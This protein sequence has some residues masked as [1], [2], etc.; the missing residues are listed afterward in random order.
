MKKIFLFVFTCFVFLY[1]NAQED[2]TNR[3]SF[4]VKPEDPEW[5]QMDSPI[6]R[7]LSLQIPNNVI[8]EI[9]TD[10]LLGLCLDYPYIIDVLF[11]DNFQKG[12]EICISEFNGFQEL[13]SREDV[14]T[15]LEKELDNIPQII[16]KLKNETDVDKGKYSFRCFFLELL[17]AQNTIL[18]K[19]SKEEIKS[20]CLSL[21]RNVEAKKT[22][23]D[24]F[25][26]M[27]DISTSLI[28]AKM[29]L[30]DPNYE[31]TE[32]QRKELT[33]FEESPQALNL[34][35]SDCLLN[36]KIKMIK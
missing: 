19:M 12:V 1:I 20:I 13:L 31:I 10:D 23:P 3:F 8:D 15:A 25:G 21:Y 28:L 29:V 6:S 14:V 24:I 36:Y 27:H 7:I 22:E 35:I 30:R 18:S 16:K 5:K 33:H 11:A 17:T 2:K 9:P 4:P 32:V 34:I 26:E